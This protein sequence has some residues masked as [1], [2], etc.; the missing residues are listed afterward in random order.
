MVCC[1]R[2]GLYYTELFP[3]IDN[4]VQAVS[5]RGVTVKEYKQMR[6]MCV[7]CACHA[8]PHKIMYCVFNN[9][10]LATGNTYLTTLLLQCYQ[11]CLTIY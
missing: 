6:T 9:T 4:T 11:D 10:L 8:F 5:M 1:A 3:I 2:F 7:L